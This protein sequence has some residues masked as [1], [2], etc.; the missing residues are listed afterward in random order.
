MEINWSSLACA[1]VTG[2]GVLR[3]SFAIENA[4]FIKYHPSAFSENTDTLLI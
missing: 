4:P 2:A 3:S 1:D